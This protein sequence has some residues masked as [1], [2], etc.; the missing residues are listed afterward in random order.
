MRGGGKID[1]LEGD[2]SLVCTRTL[3]DSTR[4]VSVTVP[5]SIF[6]FWR[7]VT[8]MFTSMLATVIFRKPPASAEGS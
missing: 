4:I 8:P 2:A 3:L 5:S 1:V 6:R 7:M